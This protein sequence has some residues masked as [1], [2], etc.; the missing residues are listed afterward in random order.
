MIILLALLPSHQGTPS[1]A[2]ALCVA[3]QWARSIGDCLSSVVL[4]AISL[5]VQ[6]GAGLGCDC[7]L[8]AMSG[9][10]CARMGWVILLSKEAAMYVEC[11]LSG[12]LR[13]VPRKG[14]F[15]S[16]L[17]NQRIVSEARGGC[18]ESCIM[19]GLSWPAML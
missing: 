11:T 10:E 3:F 4:L 15:L 2:L 18:A 1:T 8:D 14:G 5:G 9:R 6:D 19:V 12:L 13:A 17:P 16:M 7:S